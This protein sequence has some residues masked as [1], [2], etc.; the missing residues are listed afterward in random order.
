MK[1]A[2]LIKERI[3]QK[4]FSATSKKTRLFTPI[5]AGSLA[6]MLGASVASAACAGPNPKI[7]IET[8]RPNGGTITP[9]GWH[10]IQKT[11]GFVKEGGIS[12]MP[13][14]DKNVLEELRF[15]FVEGSPEIK[16]SGSGN[17][18]TITLLNNTRDARIQL[19]GVNQDSPL[20][21]G[22]NGNG[23]LI[24]DFGNSSQDRRF[25]LVAKSTKTSYAFMG[26]I[27]IILGKETGS[28]EAFYG[29][30]YYDIKS[31]I[32]VTSN[33]KQ[34]SSENDFRFYNDYT[35]LYGNFDAFA[36][37][38][39][40]RFY[41]QNSYIYGSV[42]ANN[43]GTYN[44]IVFDG[45]GS[46]ISRNITA[47]DS[48]TNNITFNQGDSRI[49]GD[50]LA[51]G[52]GSDNTITFYGSSTLIQSDGARS[53]II[54]ENAG[55]NN[56]TFK[57]GNVKIQANLITR[58]SG[59][60]RLT[61]EGN[62]SLLGLGLKTDG[63][64]SQTI[65][66]FAGSNSRVHQ[67]F[68][69]SNGGKNNFTFN[70]SRSYI[71]NNVI[72]TNGGTNAVRFEGDESYIKGKLIANGA[73]ASNTINFTGINGRITA[74]VNADNGAN[75][76]ITF[77]KTGSYIVGSPHAKGAGSSNNITFQADNAHLSSH[78]RASGGGSNTVVFA[79]NDSYIGQ[80]VTTEGSN[81]INTL[82]FSGTST[83][84]GDPRET[85][86]PGGLISADGNNAKNIISFTNSSSNDSYING[87]VRA[88]AGG[89]NT[90][91]F[92]GT[93]A[94]IAGATIARGN[95]S[96]N[97]VTFSGGEAFIG[98][99]LT[100]K[101]GGKNAITFGG[102]QSYIAGNSDA[103]GTSSENT[104]TF[105][106]AESYITGSIN[107]NGTQSK[108]TI[109]FQDGNSHI[110]G[111]VSVNGRGAINTITFQADTTEIRGD[112]AAQGGG[113]NN[114]LFNGNDTKI[115]SPNISAK[116]GGFNNI[117][118]ANGLWGE[119][120]NGAR[121]K[122][123]NT[124]DGTNTFVFRAPSNDTA[125]TTYNINTIKKGASNLVLQGM[126][127]FTTITL[128]YENAASAMFMLANN[129]DGASDSFGK[130][131]TNIAQNKILGKT[132][133]DGFKFALADK[134]I[135]INGA[136]KS[137]IE[138]Y[139]DAYKV[140]NSDKLLTVTSKYDSA[141]ASNQATITGL[142]VGTM[143]GLATTKA[144]SYDFTL[145]KNS[146]IA[147]NIDFSKSTQMDVNLVMEQGT[148][149]IID[150]KN[151]SKTVSLKN[152]E[153]KDARFDAEQLGLHALQQTNTII[154]LATSGNG[155][156]H[157]ETRKDFK[158]LNIAEQGGTFKG[159][160]ALF[161]IYV[162]NKASQSGNA[163]ATLGDVASNNGSGTYGYSYSDRVIV[164]QAQIIKPDTPLL[165]YI[166]I[167]PDTQM[168]LDSISYRGGGTENAG[169]IAIF[170]VKND[171]KNNPLIKLQYTQKRALV[172]YDVVGTQLTD[173]VR[174]D[175]N[176]KTNSTNSKDYTTYFIQSMGSDGVS[177]ANQKV[178]ISALGLNY[179]LYLAN[180]NSLNKRMGELREERNAHGAWA[181]V[182][183]GMQSTKFNA[184]LDTKAIYTTFQAG[185]DYGVN[186]KEANNYLGF[187]L[188]YANS[189]ATSKNIKEINGIT[190]GVQQANSNAIEFAIYNAYVQDGASKENGFKNGLYTDSILK[191][192]YIMSNFIFSDQN[193]TT[194]KSD[195]FALSFSQEIGYRFLLGSNKEFYIDPQAEVTLGYLSQSALKQQ[196]GQYFM[197]STQDSIFTLRSRIGSS[198]GYKF[199]RFTENKGFKAQAY[200]GTFVASD[201][202]MGGD[203]AMT[204]NSGT[205]SA[206][207]L[208]ST[209]RFVMNVGTNFKIKDNTRIYFDFER[210]F[211]GKITTDYQVNLGVR[212][213]F[214]AVDASNKVKAE[215]LKEN[216]TIKEV[217][218]TKGL[219]VELLE[220]EANTL[221]SKE[222]KVLEKLAKN[223]KTQTKI[224][225]N[226]TM[227]VYLV[228]PFKDEAKAKEAKAKLEGTL[229][230]IK[231]TGSIIEVE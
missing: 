82:T 87:E 85:G 74:T 61:F 36:G 141:N 124:E 155:I 67:A 54:A 33:F 208:T 218:P 184:A 223:L 207:P 16:S 137:L 41:G 98:G 214:G 53:S 202:F 182:F 180:L 148:K 39:H 152:L 174:T 77:S 19:F 169:N 114:I 35:D 230:E 193:T 72:A 116:T 28:F 210:S 171:T 150:N 226:K 215:T 203:V 3:A 123:L 192:S 55:N 60:N 212:Y 95:N 13:A 140:A 121:I 106:G 12:Y 113:T 5:I 8:D 200:L 187:A 94:K 40:L 170:T 157:V 9:N 220:K 111:G 163:G 112:I 38:N 209:A 205:V 164:H 151:T 86:K 175:A 11:L 22:K 149:L 78:L 107:A 195:N 101:D 219:Y 58:S 168:D 156:S 189:M 147:G 132:Y 138:V 50:I 31:N 199:D 216:N 173:G 79:G 6:V 17:K 15:N 139:G 27:D 186:L 14:W 91:S 217:E 167:I 4:T 108:N 64:N 229:K 135:S 142:A 68:E 80:D 178:A 129:N 222:K 165:E 63:A 162:N 130:D 47:K 90:I 81:S 188:S 44:N 93:R 206:K 20:Q 10:T 25:D 84:I 37:I 181:R 115:K 158:L 7:C 24:V 127:E 211:G 204:T 126:R 66:N 1:N 190:K 70:G 118:L 119:V 92:S 69:A 125:K 104:I 120:S 166:Q 2:N 99:A 131:A 45:R 122:D 143:G 198:W 221:S 172:G 197:T 159:E 224:Q 59:V 213:S 153:I 145:A 196:Q 177:L 103:L 88:I 43:Q 161:S 154:D 97:A 34:T 133:Q 73:N 117:I 136:K 185:Y 160:N 179:D 225:N 29:G 110:D 30:F 105:N 96:N 32:K 144:S 75:N 194:Y 18:A 56:F 183:N 201:V 176:G 42:S 227:K 191:L 48:G 26:N 102:T 23:K 109:T 51:N 128:N 83:H 134:I 49:Q 65:A 21:I 231:G 57:Q 146:A 89:N 228:G 46:G 100:A 76:T 52:R 62:D 71:F